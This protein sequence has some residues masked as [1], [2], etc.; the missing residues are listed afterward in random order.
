M[1][2][3]TPTDTRTYSRGEFRHP[4]HD[5]GSNV[6]HFDRGYQE[7]QQLLSATGCP[8]VPELVN[9]GNPLLS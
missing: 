2:T 4:V 9:G 8:S 1:F 7:S 6:T 3:G 5:T